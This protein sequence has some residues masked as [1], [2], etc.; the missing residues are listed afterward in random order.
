MPHGPAIFALAVQ[1][2]MQAHD[3]WVAVKV[4]FRNA[5]NMCS[6]TAFLTFAAKRFPALLLLLLAAY[7]APPYITGLGPDGWVRWLSR[8]GCTQ[9]CPL[10][11]LCFAAALQETLE[12]VHTAFP[13]VLIAA[14]HDDVQVAGPPARVEQALTMLIEGALSA[15]GLQPTGHKFTLY[16]PE[17]V[18]AFPTRAADVS[19]LEA[20]IEKWTPRDALALGKRCKAQADGIVAAGVPIG[21]LAFKRDYALSTLAA[22]QHAHSELAH[23]RDT[24]AAYLLLR[25]SLNA[26]FGFLMRA[27]EPAALQCPDLTGSVPVSVNDEMLH[28]S[29]RYLLVDP[30]VS[31]ERRTELARNGGYVLRI[32]KQAELRAKDGG[33]SLPSAEL[34]CAAAHL[35]GA[36][37]ELPYVTE[38][39]SWFRLDGADLGASS[40]L[41]YFAGL[42]SALRQ[43]HGQSTEAAT[44]YPD[45]ASLLSASPQKASQHALAE[46]VYAKQRSLVLQLQPDARHRSRVLSAGGLHAGSWL[47]VFPITMHATA[48]ARHYQLALALRLGLELPELLPAHGMRVKCGAS[49]CDADHDPYG[50]HPGVCRAGNRNGL[51]TVRHDALQLMLIHV[52]RLLG[53]ATQ[54]VSV[55]AGN[56]FGAAGYS[57]A[58]GTY[59][60][61]D[62]VLPHYLGPGRHMFLDAA[63]C[64]PEAGGALNSQPSSAEVSGVAASLRADKKV[65]KYGPLA[66]GVSS[67]F[68]AAVIE[69]FGACSDSLVGF[70]SMLCGDGHR[71]AL[72]ADDYTF[73][74]S[75]RTTYMASLLVFGTVISDAAMIDR[76]IGM[77]VHEVAAARDGA[78]RRFGGQAD[79]PGRREIEGIGGRLWY[80]LGQ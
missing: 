76:V 15:C 11:P 12:A 52:V 62:V 26:R 42:T 2:A 37:A 65:A 47:C 78:P 36:S 23:L 58:K 68:R 73:S 10:G 50:F 30:T 35:A 25:Y 39:A 24:Q 33:L 22:H 5:F 43:L 64:A 7:G 32:F 71:D 77:D 28:G 3:G 66:A 31:Q 48:R 63:V 41:P 40:P 49:R 54:S 16:A 67:Q 18:G 57:P 74:A 9:G 4:D 46:G 17:P 1:L 38:H 20:A 55:G 19:R 72:R 60:R 61:A 75:S 6:R 53:Y 51:W 8:R 59:K 70:I 69:R 13:D 27:V 34:L 44:K 21:G 56:W 14:I 29:L 79:R 45:L 80:E